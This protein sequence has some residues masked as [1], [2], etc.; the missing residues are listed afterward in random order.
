M[1][2]GFDKAYLMQNDTNLVA[3]EVISTYVYKIGL[4]TE[5]GP[6]NLSYAT[7]IG[8]FNSVVNLIALV[9]VNKIA[10]RVSGSGLW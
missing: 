4:T 2:I 9:T 3:S 7:A 10:D 8:M 5:S 6:S 1:S